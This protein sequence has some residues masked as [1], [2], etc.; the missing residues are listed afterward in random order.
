MSTATA[1]SLPCDPAYPATVEF[2]PLLPRLNLANT[3][4]RWRQL[5]DRA[6]T[7]GWSCR[8]FLGVPIT[9]EI[10][11]RQQ[12]RIPRSGRQDRFPFLNTVEQFDFSFQSRGKTAPGTGWSGAGGGL[13]CDRGGRTADGVVGMAAGGYCGL[14]G[15]STTGS[16]VR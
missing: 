5:L 2:D 1:H 9:E 8:A 4:R 6:Q 11:H 7:H 16:T 10:S 12:T 3:R 13:P 14:Q 15:Q